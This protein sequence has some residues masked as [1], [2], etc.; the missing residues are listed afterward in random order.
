MHYFSLCNIFGCLDPF[1]WFIPL[2]LRRDGFVHEQRTLRV[3]SESLSR[4]GLMGEEVPTCLLVVGCFFTWK[5]LGLAGQANFFFAAR[6]LN[7]LS[8]PEGASQGKEQSLG[9]QTFIL[10]SP[11]PDSLLHFLFAGMIGEDGP[12]DFP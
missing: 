8:F 2:Q 10:K 12:R 6:S 11:F 5:S 7:S 1:R 4:K 9:L 3:P